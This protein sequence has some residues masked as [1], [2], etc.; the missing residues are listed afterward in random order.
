MPQPPRIAINGRFLTQFVA[1][2]QRFAQ[3]TLRAMDRLLEEP[4]YRELKGRIELL[5]PQAA[6]DLPLANIP[7]RRC[8]RRSGYL[9]EQV[10]FPRAASGALLLNLCMLGP[11]AMRRQVVVVHDAIVKAMPHNFNL[12]FRAAYGFFMPLLLRRA[13]CI[14]TVSEFSRREIGKYYGVKTDTMLICHEG[15]E[16]I[17][18]APAD[19]AILKRLDLSGRPYFLCVGGSSPNKN[20]P[21]ILAALNATGLHDAPLVLTGNR[22]PKLHHHIADVSSENVIA[23]GQITDGELRA[24]YEGALALVYPSRYEGF[25]LPPLEAMNCGCPAIIS[26]QAALVEVCGDAALQCGIDDVAGLARQMRAV[27]ADQALREK[28]RQAGHE[29]AR[30]FTWTHTARALLQSCLTIAAGRA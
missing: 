12:P 15:G 23:T 25:G 5:A 9:W 4:E 28:L 2:V 10:E 24:L 20:F 13:D 6:R 21:N 17:L 7:L 11:V 30:R 19:A 27:Y 26:D 18:A 22:A 29:R 1:G 16:H 14:V 8:G 3:E